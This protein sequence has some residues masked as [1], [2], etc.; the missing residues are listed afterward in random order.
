MRWL[1]RFLLVFRC[2]LVMMRHEYC[3]DLGLFFFGENGGNG[4]S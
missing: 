2:F 4:K 3:Y 1:M